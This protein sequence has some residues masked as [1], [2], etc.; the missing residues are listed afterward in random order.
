MLKRLFKRVL[1]T[2]SKLLKQELAYE[3]KL[4]TMSLSMI[5][6]DEKE[7]A[8]IMRRKKGLADGVLHSLVDKIIDARDF[9]LYDAAELIEKDE[10]VLKKICKL[11]VQ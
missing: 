9:R 1:A 2:C 4:K 7:A 8:I 3:N 11:V 5:S 10:W 6:S